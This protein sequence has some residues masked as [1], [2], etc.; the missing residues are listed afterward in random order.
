M[1]EIEDFRNGIIIDKITF[2]ELVSEQPVSG[3]KNGRQMIFI[4]FILLC[5]LHSP[6]SWFLNS[7]PQDRIGKLSSKEILLCRLYC[8]CVWFLNS[9]PHLR[10]G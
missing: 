6:K 5:R 9:Q 1:F 3:S 10:T 2:L 4:F 8:L 7:K